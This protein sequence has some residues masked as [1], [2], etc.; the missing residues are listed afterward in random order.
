MGEAEMSWLEHHRRSEVLVSEAE[1][2]EREGQV[3]E[4]QQRYALAAEAEEL[5]LADLDRTK[6]RTRA[7]GTVSIAAL[8]FRAGHYR[9][10]ET[11]IYQSLAQGN[12][13][14]YYERRLR[15]LLDMIWS[16]NSREINGLAFEESKLDFT[17][18]GGEVLRGAAS[19]GV[20][21]GL[22]KTAESILLRTAE[23]VH[24]FPHR[25]RGSPPKE[26]TEAYQ[27]WIFQGAPGS[28]RFSVGIRSEHQLNM[29]ADPEH[30]PQGVVSLSRDIL[31]ASIN[32]PREQLPEFV[33]DSEYRSTFLRLFRSLAPSR[34]E[35]RYRKLDISLQDSRSKISLD[36]EIRFALNETIKA[37]SRADDSREEIELNGVLR[38][39][40]LERDWLVVVVHG[41]G[42]RVHGVGETVDDVI[43]PMVNQQ[44]VVTAV[45][46]AEDKL[47]YID[48]EQFE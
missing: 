35:T 28:Y 39:V 47:H 14:P 7:I 6:K 13:P 21:A 36:R 11:F 45:R 32:S 41:E 2:L 38:A 22:S 48:I 26:I 8:R 43:G 20:I 23:M 15:D 46:D 42:K 1:R 24:K 19:L 4:S 44:V 31:W 17:V 29:F 37:G 12:M 16:E 33:E 25:K 5:A 27:P 9:L 34:S 40:D 18:K 10:A 3:S 30:G